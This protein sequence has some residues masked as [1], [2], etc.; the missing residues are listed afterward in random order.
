MA[1]NDLVDRFQTITDSNVDVKSFVSG[2]FSDVNLI[3]RMPFPVALLIAEE[4][5]HDFT[6]DR[7][8][9]NVRLLIIDTYKKDQKVLKDQNEMWADEKRYGLTIW[10]AAMNAP[11][12]I[13]DK[14]SIGIDFYKKAFNGLYSIC[15][16]KANVITS[17]CIT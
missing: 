14:T 3:S 5:G 9:Y 1:L 2:N 8:S 11:D 6:L 4:G 7:G 10:K 15:E 12:Y 16:I 13:F 17:E